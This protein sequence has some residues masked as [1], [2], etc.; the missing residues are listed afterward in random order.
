VNYTLIFLFVYLLTCR[1][2]WRTEVIQQV[3]ACWVDC[4]HRWSVQPLQPASLTSLTV[5]WWT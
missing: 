5:F 2:S 4:R 1:C 3:V